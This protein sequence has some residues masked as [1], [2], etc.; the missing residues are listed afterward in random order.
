MSQENCIIEIILAMKFVKSNKVLIII[1]EDCSNQRST[2]RRKQGGIKP[3]SFAT[4]NK[5]WL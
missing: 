5:S 1:H 3:H 2:A 4:A